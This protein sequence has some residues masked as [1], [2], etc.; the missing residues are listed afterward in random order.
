MMSSGFPD[1]LDSPVDLE[2]F[3]VVS[4]STPGPLDVEECTHHLATA[5]EKPKLKNKLVSAWNNV[6]YGGWSLKSK[7]RLSKTSPVWLLGNKYQLSFADE[8]EHFRRVF[9]SLF[10]LTYRRGFQ[11]LDGSSLTSD[12]GWGC[13]LRSAQMLLAQGLLLHTMPPGWT[14][15]GTNHK[16]KDDLEVRTP[17]ARSRRRSEGAILGECEDDHRRLVKWFEDTPCSPFGLHRLVELGRTSGK[18]AGDWYGPS[19]A[20]HILRKAV[21]VSDVRDLAVY[22]AQDCTVYI[23]DVLRLFEDAHYASP[24]KHK[25]LIILVPVRLGG[26]TLNPAYADCVKQLFTLKSCIG[27]IGGKPKHSLYF[28]GFQGE[29]LLYLDPH[30]C[31][32][33][34]NMSQTSFPLESFHCKAARKL[35]IQ[36]MD[37]SCTLGFYTKSRKDFDTLRSDI[38]RVLISSTETYPIF[39]FVEGGGQDEHD[40]AELNFDPV[41]N[42]PPRDKARRR[43]K[44]SSAD[45][46]VLL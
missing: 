4:P 26:D 20:A 43:D 39:T 40:H 10:W 44:R 22:V 13:T 1:E 7:P 34:V 17:R 15:Q 6:K 14:W 37:P 35:P 45:E 8:R 21:A 18:R 33:A 23:H 36:R 42:V 32:S 3:E 2:S 24:T 31:Q 9:Y 16:T 46:F 25:A 12:G 41:I 38:T 29:Q 5:K 27:I 11:S 30:F 19:I 28:V